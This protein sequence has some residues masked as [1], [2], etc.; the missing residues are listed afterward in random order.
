MKTVLNFELEKKDACD[1]DCD[2]EES[3]SGIYAP[4]DET[5]AFGEAGAEGEQDQGESLQEDDYVGQALRGV[6]DGGDEDGERQGSE[7]RDHH[8]RE[9]YPVA[10]R[11]DEAPPEGPEQIWAIPDDPQKIRCRGP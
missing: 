4:G 7:S 1:D 5:V 3:V 8:P 10:V 6:D 9:R 2:A 11:F